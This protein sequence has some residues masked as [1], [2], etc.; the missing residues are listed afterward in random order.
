[1]AR[2]PRTVTLVPPP[3]FVFL[4]KGDGVEPGQVLR[5]LISGLCYV[6]TADYNT[7]GSDERMYAEQ[8]YERCGYPHG[9]DFGT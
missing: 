5:G 1:M 9:K 3:E 2:S 4:C 7:H 8:Y 6:R